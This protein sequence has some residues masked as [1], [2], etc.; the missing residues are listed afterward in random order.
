M[1]CDQIDM[2]KKRK[3][4]TKNL[5]TRTTTAPMIA[6]APTHETAVAETVV[7]PEPTTTVSI[8]R[9]VVIEHDLITRL[10]FAKFLARGCVHGNALED[11]LTAEAEL[12]ASSNASTATA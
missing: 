4:S 2:A 7:V 8:A 12:R 5:T 10:A 11:W 6:R 1:S 9:A 3:T